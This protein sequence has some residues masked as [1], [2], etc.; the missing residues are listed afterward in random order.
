VVAG[1]HR[2]IILHLHGNNHARDI[3]R[4]ADNR[5][6]QGRFR[7][8]GGQ[9]VERRV[10]NQSDKEQDEQKDT[11]KRKSSVPNHDIARHLPA[12]A[13]MRPI[14]A[15][16]DDRANGSGKFIAVIGSLCIVPDNR[17]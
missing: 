14:E 3:W 12:S 5:R 1:M 9:P 11:N 15:H 6:L 10:E 13:P 16:S 2:L 8:V 17:A 7:C 4:N